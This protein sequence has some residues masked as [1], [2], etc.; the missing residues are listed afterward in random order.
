MYA[1]GETVVMS[2]SIKQKSSVHSSGTSQ[3]VVLAVGGWRSVRAS[4]GSYL[5]G[6]DSVRQGGEEG[7]GRLCTQYG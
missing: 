6:I 2:Q 4:V 1:L 3:P 7:G 5:L